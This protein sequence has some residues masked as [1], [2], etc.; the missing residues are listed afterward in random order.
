ML[1]IRANAPKIAIRANRETRRNPRA[2][3]PENGIRE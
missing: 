2:A 1:T 3:T